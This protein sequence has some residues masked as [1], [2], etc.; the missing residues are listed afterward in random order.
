[1][2]TTS[3]MVVFSPTSAQADQ[4][5]FLNPRALYY[6]DSV[7]V[8]WVRGTDILELVGQDPLQGSIFYTLDQA[9]T[10]PPR[11]TRNDSVCLACHLTWDTLAVPGLTSTSMYPLP[12]N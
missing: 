3:Q 1:M 8:G 12:D 2:S 7:A 4:I 6:S 5:S 11:F 10:T 9:P